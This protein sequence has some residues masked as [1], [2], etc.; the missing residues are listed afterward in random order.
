MRSTLEFIVI[1]KTHSELI[2]KAEIEVRKYLE[3]AEGDDLAPHADMEL[4]VGTTET[5]EYAA[6]VHVRIK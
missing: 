2:A 1:A 4:K 5:K 3:L 6:H